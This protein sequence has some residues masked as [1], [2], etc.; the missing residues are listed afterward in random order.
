[1]YMVLDDEVENRTVRKRFS[2]PW[3]P[4]NYIVARG[5]KI[6]GD[7]Q[8]RWEYFPDAKSSRNSRLVIPPEVDLLVGLN[9]KFDLLWEMTQNRDVLL[10]F[11][12]RG[13]RIWDCQYV[14]Y[15]LEGQHPDFHMVSMDAI[16]PKYGGRL[17][18]GGPKDEWALGKRTSEIHPDMLIDYLVG[19]PEEGRNSGDIGNT[20][21]IFLGQVPRVIESKMLRAV[22]FRMD[23]LLATTEMEYNGLKIDIDTAAKQAVEVEAELAAV[24]KELEAYIPPLPQGLEFNWNSGY[25]VS[26][27]VFGGAIKYELRLPYKDEAGN[28]ARSKAYE[29]VPDGFYVSGKRKG[30]QK[31]KKVEIEGPLKQKYQEFIH[32]LPGYTAPSAEWRGSQK[33]ARGNFIY[34]TGSEVIEELATRDIPFLKALG[35]RAALSKDLGTYYVK[36]DSKGKLSGMLTCVDPSDHIIHHRLN[37]TNTVTS[38]LSSSDPNLQNVSTGKKSNV[39][40]VFVSRFVMGMMMEADYSQLE[41]VIQGMLSQDPTLCQFLRE[42]VDFHCKRVAAKFGIS[43]EDA[44]F[45]CKDEA[46]PD[47]H[48]WAERRQGVKEF[49]FQRA[50]GA[51][52]A[53]ISYATGMPIDDVKALIEAEDKLFPGV[54]KFNERVE[55]A[56]KKSAKPFRDG[57]RG[58]RAFRRGYWQSPT[59]CIY[60]WRTYDAPEWLRKQGVNDSFMPTEL[61]NYPIQGT[62]GE[63]MQIILGLLWREFIRMDNFEGKAL[64]CNTVHD[65]V[66]IDLDPLVQHIVA[67][68]VRRIMESVPSV[69]REAFGMDV[70]VPFP[71]EIEV[72]PN[73][74]DLHKYKPGE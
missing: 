72:G 4:E 65:C 21:K 63:V 67:A 1:M 22:Q 36:I 2:S 43:Y 16:A 14:E 12:K 26:A 15:L 42:K 55:A 31:L 52:A 45:W 8:C 10:A 74:L 23:G 71:V 34:G 5:W 7:T 32:D 11:F 61:K 48:L 20:E 39:K 28:W 27:L 29:Y 41:V 18:L 40:R 46:A 59:G 9:I 49:S 57:Q 37:H 3:H 56:V 70:Q 54:S 58:W 66:W 19:T 33:D 30:E 73:M 50:Y 6:Q 51:G 17:K 64:L 25:H 69:L 68:T 13:G 24:T 53:A 44:L 62:G 35:R 47:H 38:R 60:T